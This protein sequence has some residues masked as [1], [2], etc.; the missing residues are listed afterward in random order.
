MIA[1]AIVYALC[2]FTSAG[3]AVLLLRS[4][5]KNRST[6]LLFWSGLCFACLAVSNTILFFDGIVVPDIDLSLYRHSA[7]FVGVAMLLYGLVTEGD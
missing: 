4:A 3:C 6:P 7:T 2:A 5:A 1:A